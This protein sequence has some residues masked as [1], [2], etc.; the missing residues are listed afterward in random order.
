MLSGGLSVTQHLGQFFYLKEL[1]GCFSWFK[2]WNWFAIIYVVAESCTNPI[3][4]EENKG[5]TICGV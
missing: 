2:C 1:V 4:S 5:E 3:G